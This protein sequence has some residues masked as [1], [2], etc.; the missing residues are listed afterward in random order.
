MDNLTPVPLHSPQDTPYRV[1]YIDDEAILLKITVIYLENIAGLTVDGA[2]S[3]VKGLEMLKRQDY[4]AIIS[5]YEMPG[6]NGIELLK[7]LRDAG[8]DIPFIIF[9][10]RGREEVAIAALNAGADFYLQKGGEPEAQFTELINAV[11][12]AVQRRRTEKKL[13]HSESEKNRS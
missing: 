8:N 5:D 11:T 3:A 1:L 9:T 7:E 12:Q 10:G 2:E 6:K 13:R 4:D